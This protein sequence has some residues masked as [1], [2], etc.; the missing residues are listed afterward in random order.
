MENKEWAINRLKNLR[1]TTDKF[2]PTQTIGSRKREEHFTWIH[3]ILIQLEK[4][5]IA[6]KNTLGHYRL[7]EEQPDFES[8]EYLEGN[9][10]AEQPDYYYCSC[11]NHTQSKPSMGRG[12]NHCGMFNVMEEGYF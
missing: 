12:C 7:F 1:K 6:E 5:G 8:D 10:E 9:M 11:C 4:E 3:P 2:F